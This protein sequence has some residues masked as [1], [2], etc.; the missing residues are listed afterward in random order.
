MSSID[1]DELDD[2]H[3]QKADFRRANGAPLVSDPDDATKSLR[4]SRPSSYAKCL[5]DEE[6]LVTWKINKAMEG[7]ARSPALQ[8]Q[9]NACKAD[10]KVE[11]KLLRERALD[12]GQAT[13]RADQGTGLHAMTARAEDAAD[14]EFDPPEQY[15]NDLR[16]YVNTLEEF[17][18]VSEM[19]EVPFV[20]D[21]FRAA[22]T[23]DRVFRTERTLLTP[24]GTRIEP[25]TLI[26]GDLK[27]GKKLDFSLPGYCVQTALY[28]TGTLY[29]VVS[30]RRLATPP[31]DQ[32]WTLLIHLPVGT[33]VCRL[34][35]CSVELGLEGARLA[36]EVRTWRKL[37]KNGTYDAALAEPPS[38]AVSLEAVE[39]IE[40]SLDDM[41][42]YCQRRLN[43]IKAI[44]EATKALI[45]RWPDGLP[46]PK[47]GISN[48]SQMVTLLNLLDA[49]EAE[50]SM[51]FNEPDPRL[52]LMKGLPKAEMN[53]SN[54]F[55]LVDAG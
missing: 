29:D 4:Y 24:D 39:V 46:T 31:I 47:K 13:E 9:V 35:W 27:T 19:V 33:G 34:H 26:L 45:L 10:D 36:Q 2:E 51:P 54:E 15:L 3:E 7:V 41:A 14:V 32:D 48:P 8:I 50:F 16:A 42:A 22:G 1:I 5:D 25:G 28:A 18:L 40:V 43:A 37:W 44:P 55:L 53:R 11:R 23:A 30:E 38:L 20:N 6:A 12:K 21:R 52:V 49:V 17:G